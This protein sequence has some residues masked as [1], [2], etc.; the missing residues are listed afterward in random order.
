LDRIDGTAECRS[1]LVTNE[2]RLATIHCAK[3]SMA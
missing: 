3:P 1:A 2:K